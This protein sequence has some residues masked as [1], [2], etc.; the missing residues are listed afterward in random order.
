MKNNFGLR[1]TSRI[2]RRFFRFSAS[3]I[4][5]V[6]V[7]GAVVIRLGTCS[8]AASKSE[9]NSQNKGEANKLANHNFCS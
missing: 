8:A 6:R 2:S 4:R 5:S 7:H 9:R 3:A 1:F